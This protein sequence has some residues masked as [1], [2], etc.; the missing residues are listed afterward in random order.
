MEK[1]AVLW[2]LVNQ[3]LQDADTSAAQDCGNG[4]LPAPDR[5]LEAH[6]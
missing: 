5:Q 2:A 1:A 3:A 6:R 4:A